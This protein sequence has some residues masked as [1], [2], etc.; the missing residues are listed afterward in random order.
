M[1][2]K[3]VIAGAFHNSK[4]VI[5]DEPLAGLDPKGARQVKQL[6]QELGENSTTIFMSTHS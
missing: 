3:L 1:R 4:V 6:F 5:V 2:Q